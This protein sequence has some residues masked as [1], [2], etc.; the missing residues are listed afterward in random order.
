M[1]AGKLR[2]ILDFLPGRHVSRKAKED[3]HHR[4]PGADCHACARG[5]L[6]SAP[7]CF[8]PRFRGTAHFLA[9][10]LSPGRDPGKADSWWTH[11]WET[12][13]GF[14]GR[15]DSPLPFLPGFQSLKKST[16]TLC[17]VWPQTLS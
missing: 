10:L 4:K 13:A 1:L 2:K 7:S 17:V 3:Q 12:K 11:L 14:T 8:S 6:R 16:D 5:V 9:A 15:P